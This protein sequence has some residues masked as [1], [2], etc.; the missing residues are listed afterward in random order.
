MG[1]V[2]FYMIAIPALFA[3]MAI[4]AEILDMFIW[5]GGDNLIL[6]ICIILF[7]FMI[8]AELLKISK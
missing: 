3:I 7:P 2:F 6:L 5:W 1:A 4:I 8:L